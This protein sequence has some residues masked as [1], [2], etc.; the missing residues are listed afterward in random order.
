MVLHDSDLSRS[1]RGL[2][3]MLAKNEELMPGPR[4]TEST[5][6]SKGAARLFISPLRAGQ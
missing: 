5:E 6:R 2:A 4:T 1:I 3:A